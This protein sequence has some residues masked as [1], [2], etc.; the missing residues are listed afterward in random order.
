[1]KK[2]SDALKDTTSITEA[3]K[4]CDCSRPTL[5]RYMELYEQGE[6][7]Q[8][9]LNVRT[10]FASVINMDISR[11][12]SEKSLR[13]FMMRRS[14]LAKKM[15]CLENEIKNLQKKKCEAM[16]ELQNDPDN[17]ILLVRYDRLCEKVKVLME[18]Q[19]ECKKEYSDM[20]S[21]ANLVL[22]EC[23]AI[24]TWS[25]SNKSGPD[26]IDAEI[27]HVCSGADGNFIIIYKKPTSDSEVYVELYACIAGNDEYMGR[28]VPEQGKNFVQISGLPNT[29]SYS[30]RIVLFDDDGK[31]CT[32][33]MKLNTR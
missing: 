23:D 33:H 31:H 19:D 30:Y 32:E 2:I 9:P 7:N 6:Y 15:D 27:R 29:L 13:N 18:E 28:Y 11:T 12:A 1:M 10:Y 20:V 8:I 14:E 26:W 21:K 22:F 17:K 24:E 3:A 25:S 4:A 5:Y 16:E